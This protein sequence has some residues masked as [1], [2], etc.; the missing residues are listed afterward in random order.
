MSKISIKKGDTPTIPLNISST[1]L[2]GAKVYFTVKPA[3]DND[4]TDAAAVIS[5]SVTSHV[6]AVNG[7][8]QITITPTDWTNPLLV[9]GDYLWDIQIKSATGQLSHSNT[10][11]F[12][13]TPVTTNRTN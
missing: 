8:T 11:K 7:K 3:F 9:A 2:T 4:S 6:D 5:K 1:D 12:T 10:D 13:V